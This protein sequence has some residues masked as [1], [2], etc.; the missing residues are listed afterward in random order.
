MYSP[1]LEAQIEADRKELADLVDRFAVAAHNY[2]KS[3]GDLL[4]HR[5]EQT[6]ATMNNLRADIIESFGGKRVLVD[7]K[8][9]QSVEM[10][11]ARKRFEKWCDTMSYPTLR[12]SST[13]PD[14][15]YTN[16][17]VQQAWVAWC[18]CSGLV[19]PERE[20]EVWAKANDY[21]INRCSMGNYTGDTLHAWFAWQYLTSKKENTN[22]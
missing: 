6:K 5:R 4:P 14:S 8:T 7:T 10:V 16:S 17:K 18:G 1:E 12:W 21:N 2:T 15:A 3:L 20:F 9:T 11:A 19:S 13:D 22:V